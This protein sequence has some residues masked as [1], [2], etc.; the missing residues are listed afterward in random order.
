MAPDAEDDARSDLYSLG[1]V[2]YEALAG[3]PPFTGDSQTRMI[4]AHL[5]TTPDWA[6]LPIESWGMVRWL[7]EKVPGARPGDS[8]QL[9]AAL[10]LGNPEEA[11]QSWVEPPPVAGLS[12]YRK[13]RRIVRRS[14]LKTTGPSKPE[15][16]SFQPSSPATVV[17]DNRDDHVGRRLFSSRDPVRSLCISTGPNT[18][19]DIAGVTDR[20]V[21][22]VDVS[23]T[24]DSESPL[25]SETNTRTIVAVPGQ[26]F[27]LISSAY[28]PYLCLLPGLQ[29]QSR[30][31][32]GGNQF[33][34][35]GDGRFIT[36]TFRGRCPGSRAS[37]PGTC[38]DDR[39]L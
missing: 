36:S 29:C 2:A 14:G 26:D 21:F 4:M 9:V 10:D 1:V 27:A 3:T 31:N 23:R 37:R 17:F 35:S 8:T 6:R 18:A 12:Q 5:Q 33:A 15:S 22:R 13:S 39:V 38:A 11:K 25:T 30:S 28:R 24:A 32:F 34:C 20:S 7:L 16:S 19:G